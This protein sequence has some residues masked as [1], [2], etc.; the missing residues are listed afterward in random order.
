MKA[1][2]CPEIQGT[3]QQGTRHL[4]RTLCG[5]LAFPRTKMCS[6]DNDIP[7]AI[8]AAQVLLC[9]KYLQTFRHMII[10]MKLLTW[11][12]KLLNSTRILSLQNVQ[13]FLFLSL[14]RPTLLMQQKPFSF[15]LATRSSKMFVCPHVAWCGQ[16][17]EVFCGNFDHRKSI[18]SH[19]LMKK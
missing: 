9:V 5:K 13:I 15:L 18:K 7:L 1:E 10:L 12:L 3:F 19:T 6:K 4:R 11:A 2:F 14:W 16:Q 17:H 8:A